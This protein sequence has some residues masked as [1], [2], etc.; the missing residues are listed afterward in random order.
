M[1]VVAH[2]LTMAFTGL[3]TGSSV[4]MWYETRRLAK[5]AEAQSSDMKASIAASET[6]NKIARESLVASRRAWIAIEKVALTY[7]TEI[8]VQGLQI[9][10]SVRMKNMGETPALNAVIDCELFFVGGPIQFQEALNARKANIA[11]KSAI[12]MGYNLFPADEVLETVT[13]SRSTDDIGAAIMK[14]ANGKT[15]ASVIIFVTVGY[16]VMGDTEHRFTQ[17]NFIATFEVGDACPPGKRTVLQSMPFQE[18]EIT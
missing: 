16:K 4:A 9:T 10:L 3:L 18:G 8:T 7:P 14:L 15:Q 5:L 11:Q 12:P 6:A 1:V 2:F 13:F 17:R